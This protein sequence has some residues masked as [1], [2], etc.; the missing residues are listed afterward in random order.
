MSWPRLWGDDVIGSAGRRELTLW[1]NMQTQ[2]V[3][4]AQEVVLESYLLPSFTLQEWGTTF[5]SG[6][7]PQ[8]IQERLESSSESQG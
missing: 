7:L 1:I 5:L 4:L 8:G 3:C 6:P 2:E